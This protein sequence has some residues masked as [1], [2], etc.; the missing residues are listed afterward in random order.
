MNQL[1]SMETAKE[2]LEEGLKCKAEPCNTI[3]DAHRLLI[4]RMNI[5]T[6]IPS[7][8]GTGTTTNTGITTTNNN[9][10]TNSNNNNSMISSGSSN[11]K[12]LKAL[13]ITNDE[14]SDEDITFNYEPPSTS[15]AATM[16]SVPKDQ[17]RGAVTAI[18]APSGNNTNS[19]DV[20]SPELEMSLSSN[21]HEDA[22]LTVKVAT[23]TNANASNNCSMK[24]VNFQQPNFPNPS[25]LF[26][27][28]S[29]SSNGTTLNRITSLTKVPSNLLKLST[30][31]KVASIANISS[32]TKA[33]SFRL[34]QSAPQRQLIVPSQQQKQ[35]EEEGD[36]DD[37]NEVPVPVRV[38]ASE[39]RKKPNIHKGTTAGA[40]SMITQSDIAYMLSW[41]PNAPRKKPSQEQ[42]VV[43]TVPS[44]TVN[45]TN[46]HTSSTDTNS[47]N[48]STNSVSATNSTSG[49][50]TN[51]T[52]G[53]NQICASTNNSTTSSNTNHTSTSANSTNRQKNCAA[54][55]STTNTTDVISSSDYHPQYLPLASHSNILC[56]NGTSY[57]KLGVIGKGGSCKVYRV[58]SPDNYHIYALKKVRL[59]GMRQKEIDS[60]AN[61]V[62]LLKRLA[63][64]VSIV[65][66]VDSELDYVRKVRADIK[67]C[68]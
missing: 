53:N 61:E 37:T 54:N 6:M 11:R 48:T 12:V 25:P 14:S 21:H 38:S 42:P 49:V 20:A 1:G 3:V 62:A 57:S 59:E 15:P 44:S 40:S 27:P 13:N 58:L 5:R 43:A 56:V 16:I 32:S 46:N 17:Q 18:S 67:I 39:K 23:T 28:S 65:K 64:N 52:N 55:P 51:N 26:L 33:S 63:G 47:T 9:A 36:H 34:L 29:N 41:D 8:P 4:R 22:T 19:A 31:K 68:M 45:S 60:Y 35:N 24:R 7:L 30:K 50:N 2:V 66:F 10:T